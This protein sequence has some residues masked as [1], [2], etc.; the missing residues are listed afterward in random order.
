[1]DA[2]IM[3]SIT[4]TKV[5]DD[6]AYLTLNN[7]TYNTIDDAIFLDLDSFKTLINRNP[8]LKGLVIMGEGRHFSSGANLNNIKNSSENI[9]LLESSLNIGKEILN[10]IETLPLITVAVIK[11]IC[12]GAGVEIAMS[13]D[14]R[15]CSK[16]S[17]FS[18]P[19]SEN[20]FMPGLGGCVRLPKIVGK[21]KALKLI[22]SS[23]IIDSEEAS[24]IGL[25]DKVVAK[26]KELDEAISIINYLTNDRS[27]EQVRDICSLVKKQSSIDEKVLSDESKYF[28]KLVQT[29]FANH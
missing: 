11:G 16:N 19:E 15:V 25:V 10:Y 3:T 29:K 8:Q 22:L 4:Y 14:Y 2:I 26:G 9:S 13:C 18:F 6:I 1:M 20:G 7:G 24:K 28:S 17:K 27:V 23:E 12:F 5:I 21:K